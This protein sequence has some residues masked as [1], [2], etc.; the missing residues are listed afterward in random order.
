MLRWS[1][2]FIIASAI[3][4]R[5]ISRGKVRII[6]N[7]LFRIEIPVGR[8]KYS[9]T[10]N[11]NVNDAPLAP[12]TNISIKDPINSIMAKY[13]FL[14]FITNKKEKITLGKIAYPNLM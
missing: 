14:D 7:N 12:K 13:F 5:K 9:T 11:K 3:Y 2:N 10:N 8:R 1:D 4:G 6:N